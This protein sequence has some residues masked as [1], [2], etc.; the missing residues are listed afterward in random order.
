[1]NLSMFDR[2]ETEEKSASLP[3]FHHAY[4]RWVRENGHKY[5]DKDTFIL[6]GKQ[7]CFFSVSRHF[8][9]SKEIESDFD[10][11][12]KMRATKKTWESSQ[13]LH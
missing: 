4:K 3:F 9:F 12:K 6:C 2:T 13:V 7:L 11:E 5:Q 10:T 8:F 1:M